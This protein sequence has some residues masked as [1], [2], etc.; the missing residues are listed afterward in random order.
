MNKLTAEKCRQQI[1]EFQHLVDSESISTK[2]ER[3]LQAYRIALPVLEQQEKGEL[4]RVA[5]TGSG[6]LAAIKRGD[7]G[8][9]WGS[10]EDAHPVELF[11]RCKDV[12]CEKCNGTGQMD[13]G[14]TQPWGELIMV[15]CDCVIEQQE[16][17]NDGWVEKGARKC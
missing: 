11:A 2:A 1:E 8:F 14:G 16:K 12:V 5:F 7:E 4:V 9:I 3:H 6:S 17:G 10:K 15:E 13:S